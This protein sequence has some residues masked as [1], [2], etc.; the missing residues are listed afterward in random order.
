MENNIH[1]SISVQ[2]TPYLNYTFCL[3]KLNFLEA[4]TIEN[5]DPDIRSFQIS[6]TSSLGIIDAYHKHFDEIASERLHLA[7]FEF[8]YNIPFLRN[9]SE[10]D[11]D[12]I[13][14]T[15]HSAG[16][17]LATYSFSLDVL[18]MDYFGGLQKHPA[19]LASYVTPNHALIY[20][21]KT[22][23]VHILENR[24]HPPAFE[25]YQ[26]ESKE[27]VLQIT[28]ALFQAVRQK[29]I[30]YSAMPPSFEKIGQR[31]RLIDKVITT[32]FGNCIDISL[33]FA[34]VLESVDL[35][36][37]VIFT[38]GH[39]F[40]GV[41]LEDKRFENGINYDQAAISKRVARGIRDLVI[42]E[43]T[44]L[45]KGHNVS[46]QGAIAAAEVQLMNERN[47][48]LSIDIK[49]SRAY[50][51]SPL[52]LSQEANY[53]QKSNVAS[54][55]EEV[56]FEDE[57]YDLGETYDDLELTDL[58][59]LTKLKLW[60]RKLL[61]LSLRNNLLNIRFTRS[62]LQLVDLKI[63]L[64]ED[65]LAEGKSYTLMP[66]DSQ[67]V[68]RRY[69][70]YQP[71]LHPSNPLFTLA[72]E[73][74]SYNRLLTYYHQDD[75]DTILTHL[76]RS[77]KLAE[78]ENGKSTLYLGL[79][80]LKWYDSRNMERLAPILLI[81]VELSRR[82]VKSKFTL[83]SR[84]EETMINITLIEY[85]KQEFSLNLDALEQLPL[86]ELGVDVPKVLAIFRNAVMNLKGWDVLE[87]IV[88]GT[89]S[90]N[91][92]ILW[93]DI[94]KYTD[95]LQKSSIVKSLIDGKLA[96]DIEPLD[97]E[98]Y[99]LENL[100]YAKLTLPIPADN[101]QMKAIKSAHLGKTFILHGPPGTGK[102]QTITN[103]IA[104]ALSNDKK[105]LFVAAKK[106]ALDVVHS[107]L[108][109][110][111]LGPY[112]LELHS[113]KSKK[114]DVLKQFETALEIPRYQ[115]ATNFA[116]KAERL[117][118]RKKQLNK[119]VTFLHKKNKI[120]WSLY[121][122]ISFLEHHQVAYNDQLRIDIDVQQIPLSQYNKWVD[123]LIP[124]SALIQ[125][126]GVPNKHPFVSVRISSHN[127]D[128]QRKLIQAIDNY[129]NTHK[130]YEKLSNQ[131]EIV[132]T[133]LE[134]FKN[135]FL[136]IQKQWPE[137]IL[138]PY[139]LDATHQKNLKEWKEIQE[140]QQHLED[141]ILNLFNKNIFE[142][143]YKDLR[144]KW[145][146][147]KFSWFLPKW[148][149][150]R[151]IKK[152]LQG[153]ASSK[154]ADSAQVERL[155]SQ[156]DEFHELNERLQ[157][158]KYQSFDEV[159]R[160]YS[161]QGRLSLDKLNRDAIHLESINALLNKTEIKDKISWLI[162]ASTTD[163]SIEDVLGKLS[164]FTK[165]K[166]EL[167]HFVFSIPSN[168][169]L[170][171]MK[172][173][174]NQLEDW[175]NYQIYLKQAV[176]L[177][178]TWLTT[179][180]ETGKAAIDDVEQAFYEMLHFN[181]FI[182]SVYTYEELKSF[183]AS[184]YKS[185]ILQFRDLHNEFI[186][187]SRNQL[188]AKLSSNIPNASVEAAQSSEIG[189]LQRAIRSRGRGISIRRL[190]DQIPNL[191]PR[192]KPCML[193][194]PISVAQYFDVN[195]SH[196]DLVIFDEASQ[197]PTAE[198]V[199]ALARAKQAIIVGDPKQ[200]PPTTFFSSSTLD[201]DNL[202]IEDLESILE[203][204]LALSIPSNYLLRHYR[205]KH[206]SLISFSNKN[207]YDG[208]LLTFPSPDDLNP[209][210][211]F[212]FVD[213]HYDK[214]KTRTNR[215]EAEAVIQNI[216]NH[217]DSKNKKSVGVVTFNQAQQ[218]LIEDLLQQLFMDHPELEAFALE[219]EENIFV[220][221]L[222][223]VQ[224]DE[225]DIILFS[226]GY[227]PDED[228]N[229][230][231]NFGPLNRDGGWRRLNVA[232][233]RSR[234][235]MK[236][237][238]SL[239][240]DQ[241]NLNRTK[242]EGVRG[243]KEF[244]NYAEKG[245]Y[246]LQDQNQKQSKISLIDA[247]ASYL[248]KNGLEVKKHI[249]TSA[250]K[251][252]I[253][254][255]HPENKEEYILGILV[256]GETYYEIETTQDR[257]LLAPSVLKALGWNVFRIWTLDWIKNK[258]E[259]LK[260]IQEAITEN[261]SKKPVAQKNGISSQVLEDVGNDLLI[262][263]EESENN[264]SIPYKSADIEPVLL[265]DSDSI[266]YLTN[267]AVLLKQMKEIIEVE[268]PISKDLLFRKIRQLWNI[269]RIGSKMNQYLTEILETIPGI[270]ITESHQEFIWN[271]K[272]SPENLSHYRDNSVENRAIDD[273]SAEEL[274]VAIME[275]M[276]HNLSM[277]KSDLI[278]LCARTFNFMN[279]GRQINSVIGH[280][281]DRLIKA[282]K[283]MLNEDRVTIE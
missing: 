225:R 4:I 217:L 141:G 63:N 31:I 236:V 18:P 245:S 8:H 174:I 147:A 228:G 175:V 198:S 123:W 74:F 244:L 10:K 274:S 134:V 229:V 6:I 250:Y 204:T 124:F 107:R 233:T 145:N 43:T 177:G 108:E 264:R 56:T 169:N 2:K 261:L 119:Y 187:I 104:D 208:K 139:I 246:V 78:E 163:Y 273:I 226:I 97:E 15:L 121:Q 150:Q 120:G 161:Q 81:P 201:E 14:I 128:N 37:I 190:F 207:F 99:N 156:L 75:L 26:A 176:E 126:I 140:K 282:G 148:L 127:I 182:Q 188:I 218:G 72:D 54:E 109:S 262:Q 212:E 79:G 36:P 196:F 146:Q 3:N 52:P 91:K 80:L 149:Q 173:R 202:D 53:I 237:F 167:D 90:F 66:D 223:N 135:L 5:I 195:D 219:N 77:S 211:T 118:A 166:Q 168:E 222:E 113:N 215:Q 103:I 230:S 58:S 35:N 142:L 111:G 30:V 235:E 267:R 270:L 252:D 265:A 216:K 162:N 206:E 23:A 64:L 279:V 105:V 249:G 178:L 153:Y 151:K 49:G 87:Q 256:D 88:L 71:Q 275:I 200:M 102:S 181:H 254:I 46:F 157:N 165:A 100:S 69:N 269:G 247:I 268:A 24:G 11:I 251:V 277:E 192:L 17:D 158:S 194:S 259:I 85:L 232:V 115:L 238:S 95:E 51:V 116:E 65:S 258:D 227:G 106:A 70:N 213:G 16:E 189:I 98:N 164:A 28:S 280:T 68:T 199:S 132:P 243:L 205:S 160:L 172:R 86:D 47:F 272:L 253:G 83:R 221:N 152:V 38:E 29:E 186:N 209:K 179:M 271:D 159:E 260:Q 32:K 1:I 44:A 130:D 281:I 48:L 22:D 266:Y 76:Y 263:V 7:D 114:S 183:D 240:A 20:E 101:S 62:M 57:N 193:M 60:E 239:R 197:L 137:K 154:I 55:T 144:Q 138:V 171:E 94:T 40:V 93:Q 203:D 220:K 180:V 89:F 248:E 155:F 45:C 13:K 25:G 59:N 73:E 110:I 234:Y 34:A 241:I 191:I 185:Q 278:R 131:F 143:N 84:E 125:R 39:A 12:T 276:Q 96:A 242:A 67:L 50:G 136:A 117:D 112:C 133:K 170:L 283:L 92:L 27:R 33:L 255:V 41:W 82:S 257:E 231:M 129:L 19:L 21:I 224:G 214:G 122:T 210:V 184:V 42:V 9:L 61:D